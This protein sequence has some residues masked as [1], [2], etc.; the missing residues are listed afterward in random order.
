MEIQRYLHIL[1]SRKWIVIVTMIVTLAVVTLGSISMT[2]AYS[3][4]ALVRVA[5]GFPYAVTYTD[6]TYAERLIQT[7]VQLLKSRPFM[8]EVITRL[9][10]QVRPDALAD[11]IKVEA[12]P[13]TELIK[14]SA[15]SASPQQAA[16]IANTLAA[17]LVEQGQQMYYGQ[18]KSAREIL[19]EQVTAVDEQLRQ[20]RALLA[21][22][23]AST[24]SPDQNQ[25][26]SRQDLTTKINAEE[27]TYAMLLSQYDK[28]RVDEAMRANSV[29]IVE[30]AIEPKAPSKPNIKLNIVLGALVGL[31]GGI[32]LAF[33]FEN[34]SPML[35]SRDDLERTSGAPVLGQIPYF[36]I[37]AGTQQTTILL[38]DGNA[39]SPAAD[40]FRVLGASTLALMSKAHLKTILITSAEPEV[41]KSTIVA[42]LAAALAEAGRHV[43]V[44]DGDLRHP[45]LHQIFGTAVEPGLSDLLHD[46]S[47][48]DL[49][50][51]P[52]QIKYVRAIAGGSARFR[53]SELLNTPVVS[54]IMRQ[55]AKDADIVLWDS[56]PLL[57]AADAALLAPMADGVV[58]IVER[59]QTRREVVQAACQQLVEV[60]AKLF[61]LIVNRAERDGRY[62][63]Y[64]PRPTKD[65]WWARMLKGLRSD[66]SDRQGR[67]ILNGKQ[68]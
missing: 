30:P 53:S 54:K 25:G 24:P 15:D 64:C 21:S 66:D 5:T 34:L 2:P 58:L 16:A 28:T 39:Q 13:D 63:Y 65:H 12:L 31:M 45:C 44:V 9:N 10:L 52:T 19:Q 6:L 60:E 57:A 42:N 59:T 67:K 7:Y 29:S 17:L 26:V 68:T 51:Q 40:S 32:G 61:G 49:A 55:L 36:E 50:M 62:N 20:D 3:T 37:Q 38:N 43:I 18:G 1:K 46:P 22:L 48:L 47:R 11:T 8:E 14:I 35:H 56:P 23:D 27:Q 33:L 41:G 4:S